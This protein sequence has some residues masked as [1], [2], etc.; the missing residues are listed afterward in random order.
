MKKIAFLSP[1]LIAAALAGCNAESELPE[2]NEESENPVIEEG[3]A[4][5][6]EYS[7]GVSSDAAIYPASFESEDGGT[8]LPASEGSG[9]AEGA[10][11][12]SDVEMAELLALP[13]LTA[14]GPITI[15]P[16]AIPEIIQGKDDRRKIS[17]TA[18]YP[19]SAQTLI[20]LP[21]GRCS[22]AMIGKDL[23]ITAGHCVH[24]NGKWANRATV[25]P[26]RNGRAAPF[27]SCTAKRF[28]SLK[29]WTQKK[30]SRYDF[31]AIKLNCS[32]GMKTGWM[33]V[34][35]SNGSINGKS[36]IISSYPGDKPLE[37]WIDNTKSVISSGKL[38]TYYK[39]DTVGGNSGS[40]VFSTKDAP[41][42]CRGPCVHTA[43]AYGGRS[44]NSGS[45]VNIARLNNLRKWMA[46]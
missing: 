35:A 32:I 34:F 8:L 18:T 2:A 28:Y 19:Y 9:T 6:M 5:D 26:G 15:D 25:F 27:G 30:D 23:V 17:N 41:A 46:E 31:G 38:K 40:G 11:E 22:G 12:A 39:T 37:Q 13:V 4:V 1:V 20:V 21:G 7:T 36:A 43:H 10:S 29:G 44:A 3:D 16:D 42:G 45:H 24:R 33:G 14:D